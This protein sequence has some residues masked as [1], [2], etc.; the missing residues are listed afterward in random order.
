MTLEI[1]TILGTY[2]CRSYFNDDLDSGIDISKNGN[3][4]GSMVE[5]S[6][7]D[8]DDEDE[9]ESFIDKLEVWLCENE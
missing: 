4:V 5:A 9:M 8:E 6:L 1:N 2:E 7:P 3:R